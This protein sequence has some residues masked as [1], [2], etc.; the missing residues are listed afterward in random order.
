ML[1]EQ[2]DIP[3]YQQLYEIFRERILDGSLRSN[4]RLPAEQD[5]TQE[6]GISRITVK[7]ALN[8]LAVAGLVRRQRGIGTVVT[9]NAKAPIIKGSFDNM[10]EGLTRIGLSTEVR[11]LDCSR[12]HPSPAVLSSLEL[13][14]QAEVQRVVRLRFLEG[15]PLSYLISHIPEAVA[16][17]YDESELATSSLIDLLE[18]AGHSPVE[19]EQTITAVTAPSAVAANLLVATG[20]PLLQIH[21]IMRDRTGMPVQDIVAHYRPDRFQYH[22]K[23]TRKGEG[24]VDWITKS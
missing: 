22:M 5:L 4:E 15:E 23:F 21:R 18:R 17:R 11:L 2:S 12:T 9:F 6:L 13:E 7:R 24:N 1:D 8:E 10:I 14:P 16:D 19:A 20:S 3:L